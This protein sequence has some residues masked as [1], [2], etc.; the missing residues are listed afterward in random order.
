MKFAYK[1]M[2]L[3]VDCT[4]LY[5]KLETHSDYKEFSFKKFWNA[6]AAASNRRLNQA[7]PYNDSH[8]RVKKIPKM[9]IDDDPLITSREALR[10]LDQLKAF[11][12]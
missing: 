5:K 8:K 10:I 3:S 11:V 6:N 12:Q 9:E 4:C 1:E 7:H 2:E